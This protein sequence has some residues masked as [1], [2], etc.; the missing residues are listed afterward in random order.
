ML[1]VS[2]PAPADETEHVFEIRVRLAGGGVRA[3]PAIA[4][5]SLMEVLRA[6]DV[7][8]VAECG[9]AAVCASCHVRVPER[10]ADRLPPAGDEELARLD[11][12]A[13]ADETSRLACQIRVDADLDGLEVDLQADSLRAGHQQR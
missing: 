3:I 9:G 7:P 2:A 12:I 6:N 5:L 4:G 1:T 13:T 10:F 11:D 8:I